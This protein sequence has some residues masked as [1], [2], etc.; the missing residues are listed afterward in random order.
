MAIVAAQE[1]GVVLG[2]S[3]AIVMLANHLTSNDYTVSSY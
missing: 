3:S 1:S 2:L